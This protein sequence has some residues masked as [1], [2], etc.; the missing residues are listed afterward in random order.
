[1]G[2]HGSNWHEAEWD[3]SSGTGF[4]WSDGE[5]GWIELRIDRH[6]P[7]ILQFECLSIIGSA[8]YDD[9]GIVVDTEK[10]PTR[11]VANPLGAIRYFPPPCQL[12]SGALA[13]RIDSGS[14]AIRLGGRSI[15]IRNRPT[16][17]SSAWPYRF[18][19]S[20]LTIPSKSQ[21]PSRP[22]D[23]RVARNHRV[24]ADKGTIW[25]V[26]GPSWMLSFAMLRC[27]EG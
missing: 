3:D 15:S 27:G 26:S 21:R 7:L 23:R 10:L 6:R 25:L 19:D 5:T 24:V 13:R 18:L 17:A 22:S 9:I 12:R 11:R 20:T 2:F 8:S 16:S 4:R 1:M 14:A